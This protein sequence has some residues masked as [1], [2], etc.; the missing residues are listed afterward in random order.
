MKKKYAITDTFP[1]TSWKILRTI[2]WEPLLY[3][4][5]MTTGR[6][7]SGFLEA[8]AGQAV[9]AGPTKTRVDPTLDWQCPT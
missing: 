1:R 4:I 9:S 8:V 3:S 6:E 7:E 5:G 2:G